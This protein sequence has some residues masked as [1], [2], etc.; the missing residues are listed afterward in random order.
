MNETNTDVVNRQVT[1]FTLLSL[2]IQVAHMY[3]II[4][5]LL[6][7][8]N[9]NASEAWIPERICRSPK[10]FNLSKMCARDIYGEAAFVLGT[11][12]DTVKALAVAR[13]EN[14]EHIKIVTEPLSN[15]DFEESFQVLMKQL[16]LSS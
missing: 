4:I 2:I 7:G 12:K 10:S 16:P 6:Y 13:V 8:P 9:L 11:T 14:Y 3:V 1:I 15:K 5:Y